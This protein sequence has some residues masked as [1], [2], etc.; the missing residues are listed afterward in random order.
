MWHPGEGRLSGRR[1]HQ[2][3]ADGVGRHQHR[4]QQ[5]R[6]RLRHAAPAPGARR[7]VSD[8]RRWAG[9]HG[10]GP[11]HAGH[12]RLQH[13]DGRAHRSGIA[14][15]AMGGIAGHRAR[16]PRWAVAPRPRHSP[17]RRWG[18][19]HRVRP[20]LDGDRRQQRGCRHG[21]VRGRQLRRGEWRDLVCRRQQHHRRS[22]AG[23]RPPPAPHAAAAA[24]W[25]AR[26]AGGSSGPAR[27]AP[28]PEAALWRARRRP[29]PRRSTA[30]PSPGPPR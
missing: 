28:P 19:D 7:S 2:R 29:R 30:P 18:F 22:P 23:P 25:R 1:S 16:A 13:L 26:P 3:G 10:H 17:A 4:R 12:Q 14:S 27:S 6:V 24:P 9:Q 5:R 11:E 21:V 8:T 20:L 15:T